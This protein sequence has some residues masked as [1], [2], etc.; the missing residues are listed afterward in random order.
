MDKN[1]IPNITNL[2]STTTAL[3]DVENKISNVSNLVKILTSKIFTA[4]LA[5]ANLAKNNDIANC[6]KWTDFDNE[7]T[8]L[9]KNELTELS[10]K[11]KQSQQ[12]D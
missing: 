6:I 5:Q 7:L 10:N 2:A 4:R 11:S 8:N 1:K 3:T 12:K 9:S